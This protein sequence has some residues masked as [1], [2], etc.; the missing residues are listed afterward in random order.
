MFRCGLRNDA[1]SIQRFY[2]PSVPSPTAY[3]G[4]CFD[5]I[6]RNLITNTCFIFR[7]RKQLTVTFEFNSIYGSRLIQIYYL[8][9]FSL[10]V[11]YQLSNWL[12]RNLIE[13]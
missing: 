6:F 4:I 9:R 11:E 1:G 12:F 13:G 5:F 2:F 3:E 10:P 7:P 8:S